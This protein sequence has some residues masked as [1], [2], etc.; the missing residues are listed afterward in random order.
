MSV[1]PAR[2]RSTF[3]LAVPESLARSSP[4]ATVTA[5]TSSVS[6]VSEAAAR[7]TA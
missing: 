5:R 1:A 7:A 6:A 4:A 3:A 2:L